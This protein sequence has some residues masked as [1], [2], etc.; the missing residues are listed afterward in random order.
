LIWI[1]KVYL[2]IIS[3]SLDGFQGKINF[4]VLSLL[5]QP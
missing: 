5:S 2:D 1:N 4:L 3:R